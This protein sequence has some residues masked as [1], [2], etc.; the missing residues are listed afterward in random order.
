MR[1]LLFGS[2]A[3]RLLAL[4]SLLPDSQAPCFPSPLGY[5]EAAMP[6]R[7][8]PLPGTPV[9]VSLPLSPPLLNAIGG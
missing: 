5:D 4:A 9:D 7:D 6:D 2:S 3:G 8:P 1:H